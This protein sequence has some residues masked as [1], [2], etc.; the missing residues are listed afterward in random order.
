MLRHVLVLALALGTFGCASGS[1]KIT[2]TYVSPM[3]YD[4][5]NCK[6]LTEEAQRLSSRAAQAA[7]AQDSQATKDAVATTV[8]VIVFW[9]ALF[10]I[11]GDKQN[12]AEL[13]RLKGEM[14][15]VEQASIRK[16]CG[17][18]FQTAPPG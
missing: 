11:G 10:F 1:D 18:Q 14:D 9:P 3:Q 2:A 16:K 8:G 15:A 17:I 6:Q 4:A 7:G 12:A 13:A 5:Y